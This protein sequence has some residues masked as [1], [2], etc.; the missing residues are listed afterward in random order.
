MT[1]PRVKV[2]MGLIAASLIAACSENRP[3]EVSSG[4]TGPGVLLESPQDTSSSNSI[5]YVR[6]P[7]PDRTVDA[8]SVP[9]GALS[10]HSGPILYRTNTYAIFWGTLWNT[11]AQFTQD[12]ITAIQSFFAG[13]GGSH[14]ANIATEYGASNQSTFV[15]TLIDN[16]AA[17]QSDPG[18]NGLGAHVCSL[19]GTRGL[20]SDPSGFYAVYVTTHW[21]TGT[22]GYLGYHGAYACRGATLH[23]A[24]IFNM[25]DT[26][27]VPDGVYHSDSA[28]ALADVTAHELME[29]IT[30]PLPVTGWFVSSGFGEIGDKCN[31]LFLPSPYST[32][33]NGAVF[34]LQDEWSNAAFSSGS[35]YP[36][37]NGERGCVNSENEHVHA[38]VTGWTSIQQ[39]QTASYTA[40]VGGGTPPYSYDWQIGQFQSPLT[41][42]YSSN[43]ASTFSP[44]LY[45]SVSTPT[46]YTVTVMVR[47][48]TGATPPIPVGMN[49]T[50]EP[51]Q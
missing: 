13:F 24:I 5:G 3:T 45:S 29:T 49:A 9:V 12:K 22:G 19:L 1:R 51:G 20:S 46:Q 37:G 50:A 14:Y 33:S 36:N 47:D 7:R 27:F 41:F 17:P 30:D 42:G 35:G 10:W 11:N 23:L 6:P 44:T 18:L 21:V 28:A 8:L 39:F 25:D 34:K 40:S 32:L 2:A 4:A 38:T 15:T 48:A 16:T 43:S 26:P 31:L